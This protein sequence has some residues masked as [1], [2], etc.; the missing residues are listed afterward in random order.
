MGD[1]LFGDNPPQW[2]QQQFTDPNTGVFDGNQAR[3]QFAQLKKRMDDPR[4]QTA[5]KE[6]MGPQPGADPAANIVSEVQCAYLSESVYV[7]K[8]LAEKTNADNGSIAKA[9]FV[10]VPYTTIS[11]SAVKVYE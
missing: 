3:Q 10:Y 7:P 1:V 9:S 6:Y 2:I 11:D 4:V 5:Y 8:W